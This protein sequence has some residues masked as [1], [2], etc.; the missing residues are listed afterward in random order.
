[1]S[2]ALA[3]PKPARLKSPAYLDWIKR[4]SCLLCPVTAVDPHHTRKRS[5]G[6]S[7]YRALPLCRK[8]HSECERVG[9]LT[10]QK[11]H[12][13]DFAEEIVRHLE[14]Y[15]AELEREAA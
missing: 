1:M 13:I 6:G 8:H 10:F 2:A 11:R 12:H 3:F 9:V 15:V 14:R 4:H 5:V 7:D